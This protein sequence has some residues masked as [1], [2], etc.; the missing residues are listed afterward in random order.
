VQSGLGLLASDR[1]VKLSEVDQA[2]VGAELE[3]GMIAAAWAEL[4]SYQVLRA[5][6]TLVRPGHKSVNYST[7]AQHLGYTPQAVEERL[8]ILRGRGAVELDETHDGPLAA[9]LTDIG[10]GWVKDR[11]PANQ[12]ALAATSSHQAITVTGDRNVLNV[13]AR[14]AVMNRIQ[15]GDGHVELGRVLD[16][17]KAALADLAEDDEDVK[18]RHQAVDRLAEQLTKAEPEAR[19]VNRTWDRIVAFATVED[20]IRGDERIRNA[21]LALWPYVKPWIDGPSPML[22]GA[23]T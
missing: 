9:A 10:L 18:D 13:A 11:V 16:E 15:T 1:Q 4:E 8:R 22:P 6:R 17:V 2:V 14:D 20:A 12:P 19:P 5:I 3:P 23:T 21:L 7:I